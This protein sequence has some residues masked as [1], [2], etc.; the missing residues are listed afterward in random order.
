MTSLNHL[1]IKHLALKVK[2]LIIMRDFYITALHFAVEWQP[3]ELSCYL[4]SGSDSLAL[5]QV[6]KNED[7][8]K[9]SRLDHLGIFTSCPEEVEQWHGQ[10]VEQRIIP[11]TSPK[12]HRDGAVSFYLLDP[13]E[14]KLQ[15]LYY[16]ITDRH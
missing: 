11:L 7:I 10:L 13:E 16:P 5:H 2:N 9:E 15:I 3:D 1:G 12:K 4:S 14:N 8:S 6:E